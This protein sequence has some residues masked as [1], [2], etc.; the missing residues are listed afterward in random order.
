[1]TETTRENIEQVLSRRDDNTAAVIVF[2]Q[3]SP[4]LPKTVI[5]F[6]ALDDLEGEREHEVVVECCKQ[7]GGELRFASVFRWPVGTSDAKIRSCLTAELD[8]TLKS[9][10]LPTPVLPPATPG[11]YC[12]GDLGGTVNEQFVQEISSRVAYCREKAEAEKRWERGKGRCQPI[13]W[14]LFVEN[15]SGG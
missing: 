3:E 11:R 8:A 12:W 15:T 9:I 4:G 5:A 2:A 1:M 7:T 10:Y 13:F 6:C 14:C